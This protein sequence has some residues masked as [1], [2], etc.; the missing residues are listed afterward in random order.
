MSLKTVFFALVAF[1]L[2]Q[3]PLF[4]EDD[5]SLTVGIVSYNPPYVIQGSNNE[6]YGYDVDMM[7]AVCQFMNKTCKFKVMKADELIK[8]VAAGKIDLAIN[9]LT[10]TTNRLKLVNF[11]IP[12]SLSMF[13]FLTGNPEDLKKPFSMSLMENKKIG[14]LSGSIFDESPAALGI[15]SA[16]IIPYSS[17]SQLVED[18][19][20]KKIDF[21]LVHDPVA[22]YWDANTPGDLT[23]IGP[24]FVMGM[25]L[26]VV[27]NKKNVELLQ[28][29]NKALIQFQDS[30]L[31]KKNFDKYLKSF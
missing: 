22:L 16:K 3:P 2:C 25:G 26:G 11:T 31:Y 28:E 29:V 17:M 7:R 20:N 21:V 1:I 24:A 27:V 8:G 10:I 23:K 13:R 4:A 30:P 9:T 14:V 19:Y 15:V 6:I 5:A 18:L 12:Y